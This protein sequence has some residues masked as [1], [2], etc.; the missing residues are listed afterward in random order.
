M[1]DLCLSLTTDRNTDIFLDMCKADQQHVR[2]NGQSIQLFQPRRFHSQRKNINGSMPNVFGYV[3]LSCSNFYYTS[4][5]PSI[6]YTPFVLVRVSR[7][8]RPCQHTFWPQ[9][10]KNTIKYRKV[11]SISHCIHCMLQDTNGIRSNPAQRGV[12]CVEL[13]CQCFPSCQFLGAVQQDMILLYHQHSRH[14]VTSM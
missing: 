4:I 9:A 6:F 11:A 1:Y 13:K 2:K 7:D 14:T 3:L 5:R 8:W 10:E 12:L